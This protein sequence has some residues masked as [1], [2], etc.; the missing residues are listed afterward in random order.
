[1]IHKN[2]TTWSVIFSYML[3][4]WLAHGLHAHVHVH[5][6]GHVCGTSEVA[7][8]VTAEK[9]SPRQCCQHGHVHEVAGELQVAG[10]VETARDN[11]AQRPSDQTPANDQH[12][13]EGC[14]VCQLLFTA[15]TLSITF[16]YSLETIE[17]PVVKQVACNSPVV[18]E[19]KAHYTR[20]PPIV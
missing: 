13:H 11:G 10:R 4:G 14:Q 8:G 9:T 7:I 1:M 2:L 3:T 18:T 17:I 19:I 15:V 5:A 20:G 16:N 12:D 6:G